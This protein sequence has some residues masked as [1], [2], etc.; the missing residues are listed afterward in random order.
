MP[1]ME[2]KRAESEKNISDLIGPNRT[3][4]LKYEALSLSRKGPIGH[5]NDICL[6]IKIKKDKEALIS[7]A[8][9]KQTT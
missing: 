1:P 7:V 9:L 3:V 5:E 8:Y 2:L 6:K 4:K